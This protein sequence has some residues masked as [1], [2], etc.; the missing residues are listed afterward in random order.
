MQRF[1][2]SASVRLTCG[3]LCLSAHWRGTSACSTFESVGRM[4]TLRGTRVDKAVPTL[5]CSFALSAQ[6]KSCPRRLE[7]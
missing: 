4:M 5:L 2:F 7:S 6:E 3:S 1:G